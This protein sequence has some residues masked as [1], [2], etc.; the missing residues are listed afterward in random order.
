MK[1]SC[2]TMVFLWICFLVKW[3][4]AGGS[5]ILALCLVTGYDIR[6]YAEIRFDGCFDCAK[7]CT[8]D[9]YSE[10]SENHKNSI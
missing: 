7:A 6:Y 3:H 1:P 4:Y 5:R 8:K 2:Y 9:F 10:K